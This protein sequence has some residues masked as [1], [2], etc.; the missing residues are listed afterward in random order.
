MN[1][2]TRAASCCV[3]A[4]RT[5]E[6][7][8]SGLPPPASSERPTS[9]ARASLS[10]WPHAP[11]PHEERSHG[12][13][14]AERPKGSMACRGSHATS[15]RWAP[16]AAICCARGGRRRKCA[17]PLVP[18]E[19]EA[20]TRTRPRPEAE[21]AKAVVLEAEGGSGVAERVAWGSACSATTERVVAPGGGVT[22][23]RAERRSEGRTKPGTACSR[24]E[25]EEESAASRVRG[26]A[27]ASC[28]R[29]AK[30]RT[31]PGWRSSRVG[32]FHGLVESGTRGIPFLPSQHGHGVCGSCAKDGY[33]AASEA[34]TLRKGHCRLS[35]H[36]S[37]HACEATSHSYA[38]PLPRSSIIGRHPSSGVELRSAGVTSSVAS[39]ST[40]RTNSTYPCCPPTCGSL[41]TTD[42]MP[43]GGW[44]ALSGSAKPSAPTS[45]AAPPVAVRLSR[46]TSAFPSA[47]RSYDRTATS[48]SGARASLAASAAVMSCAARTSP[49]SAWGSGSAAAPSSSVEKVSYDGAPTRRRR[50]VTSP[51]CAQSGRA[52]ASLSGRVNDH[53]SPSRERLETVYAPARSARRRREVPP[54]LRL[55]AGGRSGAV[56]A[57]V[58]QPDDFPAEAEFLK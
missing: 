11:S 16:S 25:P 10:T 39:S 24:A 17:A 38:S 12:S 33:S 53:A 26:P 45:T 7:R 29:S 22:R 8:H 27:G 14:A 51:R 35:D 28:R 4:A 36:S 43:A 23:R 47:L 57:Q 15:A 40:T 42:S 9:Y 55:R 37:A 31:S 34:D 52:D 54:T 19:K 13:T 49:P 18:S 48:G 41:H 46:S 56:F 32:S 58:D 50:R 5:F 21:R 3:G 1:S 44:P 30:E 20:R 6:A 2:S